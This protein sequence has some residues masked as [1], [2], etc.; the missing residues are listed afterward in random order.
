VVVLASRNKMPLS[1]D[2]VFRDTPERAFFEFA[3][4]GDPKTLDIYGTLRAVTFSCFIIYCMQYFGSVFA[5]VDHNRE[6]MV[7]RQ[8]L[9]QRTV[10]C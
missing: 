7:N 9:A 2:F 10:A 5:I 8:A 4:K 3:L 6:A 1:L